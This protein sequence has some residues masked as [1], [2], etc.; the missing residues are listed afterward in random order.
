MPV[1]NRT[2]RLRHA[3]PAL[4]AR[5]TDRIE[6][7]QTEWTN[8]PRSP[9]GGWPKRAFDFVASALGLL[10]VA[11]LLATLMLLVWLQDGGPA[12]YGQVRIGVGGRKFR[13]LKLRSMMVDADAAL[14]RHLATD[15]EA[16]R[17]WAETRKLR[18]DPRITRLGRFLRRS[19]LDELPQLFNVLR[20]EM[21]LVG[22]R[23]VVADELE[24]YGLARLHYLRSRPGITGLWQISG[25]SDTTYERRIE[26]DREYSLRWSLLGDFQILVRTLPAILSQ[27]GA[28]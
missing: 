19:S 24:R 25:R 12:L 1:L 4:P 22:P 26:L 10:F 20:G 27:K 3:D 21:S 17:E 16:A 8:W 18:N 7:Q 5:T 11:P 15:P 13:C 2:A 14:E 9:L 28:V 23:P 6:P